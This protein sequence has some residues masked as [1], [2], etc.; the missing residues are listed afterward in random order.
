M[1]ACSPTT[2]GNAESARHHPTP[3]QLNKPSCSWHR[4]AAA[5]V[6]APLLLHLSTHSCKSSAFVHVSTQTREALPLGSSLH[7][8]HTQRQEAFSRANNGKSA[9]RNVMF[10]LFL[11]AHRARKTDILHKLAGRQRQLFSDLGDY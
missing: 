3:T 2:F 7:T 10:N 8:A 4:A 11:N 6:A 9:S 1:S 5:V